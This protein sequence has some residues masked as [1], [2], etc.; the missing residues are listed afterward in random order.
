VT[1]PFCWYDETILKHRTYIEIPNTGAVPIRG[2]P[3]LELTA[4]FFAAF[5]ASIFLA[6]AVEAY[7]SD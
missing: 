4:A 3:M 7:L 6:H 2:F 5:G 1:K